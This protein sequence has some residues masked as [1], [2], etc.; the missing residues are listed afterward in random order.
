MN[1]LR[2]NVFHS[3]GAI[4]TGIHGSAATIECLDGACL[5]TE[6]GGLDQPVLAYAVIVVR[7]A[8]NGANVRVTIAPACNNINMLLV[9]QTIFV[10]MIGCIDIDQRNYITYI[11][12]V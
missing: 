10:L 8:I 7:L 9:L 4:D 3:K 5:E 11:L 12:L 2:P 1:S 6:V